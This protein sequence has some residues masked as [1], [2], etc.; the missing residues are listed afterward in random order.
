MSDFKDFAGYMHALSMK[1]I[2]GSWTEGTLFALDAIFAKYSTFSTIEDPLSQLFKEK[3]TDSTADLSSFER[4]E[5]GDSIIRPRSMPEESS[6]SSRNILLENGAESEDF[7]RFQSL[8]RRKT[9]FRRFKNFC[10]PWKDV[11][12]K[13]TSKQQNCI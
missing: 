11:L 4:L 12:K 2:S 3:W 13:R 6:E 1:W 8:S 5:L 9:S 7:R 10:F